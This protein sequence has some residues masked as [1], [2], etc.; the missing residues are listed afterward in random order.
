[1]NE[2]S[3]PEIES[4]AEDVLK[5]R[6]LNRITIAAVMVVGL[7]G[8]LAMF[9]AIYAP[10]HPVPAKVAAPPPSGEAP[11]ATALRP[12]PSR[13]GRKI[14]ASATS[15]AMPTGMPHSASHC[16]GKFSACV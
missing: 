14:H 13:P 15:A 11:A 7:L 10:S 6:L 16:A 4:E 12:T 3:T 9:D 5:R 1:M 2:T 8:S